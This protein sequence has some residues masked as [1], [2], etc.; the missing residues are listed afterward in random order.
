[1]Q[2]L[3]GG[4]MRNIAGLGLVVALASCQFVPGTDAAKSSEAR[5]AIS[6]LLTDP[7]SAQFRNAYV[8]QIDSDNGAFSL[9]CGEVNGKNA[10]G[11]Y[12]GFRRFVHEDGGGFSMIDPATRYTDGD[13]ALAHRVCG[14]E[15]PCPQLDRINAEI[16]D[17]EGFEAVW[18]S[19]S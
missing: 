7:G 13:A 3:E 2:Q 12:A 8:R 11:A 15:S 14:F 17:Q 4:R 16:S 10:F 6:G 1:M 5:Q 18:E 19:C 9:V